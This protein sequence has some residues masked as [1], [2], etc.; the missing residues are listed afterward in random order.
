MFATTSL[1]GYRLHANSTN[2]TG[3]GG[4]KKVYT[5]SWHMRM[6][7]FMKHISNNFT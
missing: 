3:A 5:P 7:F 2:N 4:K 1:L 6:G